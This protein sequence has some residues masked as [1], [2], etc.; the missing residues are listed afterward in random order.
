[1]QVADLVPLCLSM[2][3]YVNVLSMNAVERQ[4]F[5]LPLPAFDRE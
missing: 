2:P 5:S 3:L 1:L 4:A